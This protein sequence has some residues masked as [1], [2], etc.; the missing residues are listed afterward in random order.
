[1]KFKANTIVEHFLL[2]GPPYFFFVVAPKNHM[3]TS[4]HSAAPR[5][6][7]TDP[8]PFQM[9]FTE[10]IQTLLCPAFMLS[11]RL[12]YSFISFSSFL[13]LS[14]THTLSL[15]LSHSLSNNSLSLTHTHTHSLSLKHTHVH[16]SFVTSIQKQLQFRFLV[17]SL[18]PESIKSRNY[19]V[20]LSFKL[21]SEYFIFLHH[22]TKQHFVKLCNNKTMQLLLFEQQTKML[23]KLL[24]FNFLISSNLANFNTSFKCYPS[25]QISQLGLINN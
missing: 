25:C 11:Y 12:Q 3:H 9:N 4:H 16:S 18:N 5:G 20:L 13:F 15:S 7:K 19:K 6:I 8:P 2:Q 24:V 14:H 21:F 1:M 10:K 17:L 23:Q 22:F